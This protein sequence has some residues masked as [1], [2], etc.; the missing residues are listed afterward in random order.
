MR[1]LINDKLFGELTEKPLVIQSWR[2]LSDSY[3]RHSVYGLAS[4]S[5]RALSRRYDAGRHS[6]IRLIALASH[7]RSS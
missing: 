2:G 3:A 7:H 4:D 1:A 6:L 5:G